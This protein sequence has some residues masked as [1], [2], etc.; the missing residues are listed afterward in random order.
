MNNQI[1]KVVKKKVIQT[2]P[3]NQQPLKKVPQTKKV[4]TETQPG[5]KVPQKKSV[6]WLWFLSII[7]L[8]IYPAIW[9][10]KRKPEFDNL[11]TQKKLSKGAAITYLIFMII[12]IILQIANLFFKDKINVFLETTLGLILLS[13][14]FIFTILLI[15]LS[16]KLAFNTRT[17]LNQ[18]M[19]NKGGTRKASWFFTLIF[20]F[21]YLQY[22]INRIIDDRENE[23]RVGP[24]ACLTVIILTLIIIPFLMG[25]LYGLFLTT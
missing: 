18:T 15:Y 1:K 4:Q 17:I 21:L 9:Y 10:I 23:K 11:K 8:G 7:T 25:L 22:E 6:V 5:P 3:P 12:I 13:I 16:L 2:T 14:G 19:T 20:N 24:W